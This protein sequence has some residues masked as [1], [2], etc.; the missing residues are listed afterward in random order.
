[1][2]FARQYKMLGPP[3]DKDEIPL[4]PIQDIL[5]KLP[6]HIYILYLHVYNDIMLASV[7]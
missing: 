5:F 2:H 3:N 7:S 6:L 1:M 4:V